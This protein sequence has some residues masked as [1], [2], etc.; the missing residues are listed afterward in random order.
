MGATTTWERWDSLL[1]DGSVN[2][3]EMTSF[4]H[5][6]LGAVAD[7]IHRTVGGIAPAEPGYRALV[8]RPR[9]GGG[10]TWARATHRTPYGQVEVHWRQEDDGHL[11]VE[12]QIPPATTAILDLPGAETLHLGPGHHVHRT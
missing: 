11:V 4:N 2:P 10:I 7:W 12:V 3:G 1:P 8:I 9:P 5:Y 6:A